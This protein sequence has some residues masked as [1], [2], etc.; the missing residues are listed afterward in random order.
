VTRLSK[1]SRKTKKINKDFVLLD[2]NDKAPFDAIILDTS[3]REHIYVEFEPT[4]M[5]IPIRI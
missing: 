3:R 5:I 2:Y 1:K 4:R